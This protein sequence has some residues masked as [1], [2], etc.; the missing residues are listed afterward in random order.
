MKNI[1]LI[2]S[3]EVAQL[4]NTQ[5]ALGAVPA[6]DACEGSRGAAPRFP[7]NSLGNEFN[8]CGKEGLEFVLL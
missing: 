5:N 6:A 2:P 3:L 1:P 7:S 8:M 4:E